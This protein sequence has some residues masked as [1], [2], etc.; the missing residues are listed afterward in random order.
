MSSRVAAA[1][2]WRGALSSSP[3]LIRNNKLSLLTNITI[4]TQV[5]VIGE[6]PCVTN[7]N[8]WLNTQ[9]TTKQLGSQQ[10]RQS[11]AGM[12]YMLIWNR[13]RRYCTTLDLQKTSNRSVTKY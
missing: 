8:Q 4:P 2:A 3:S 5:V 1:L 9:S 10:K 11:R 6:L 7:T 13:S 12:P